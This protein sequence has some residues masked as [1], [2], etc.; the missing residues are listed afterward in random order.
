MDSSIRGLARFHSL[1]QRARSQCYSACDLKKMVDWRVEKL[2]D[3]INIYFR[4]SSYESF[5]VSNLQAG[6]ACDGMKCWVP[7]PNRETLRWDGEYI[8]SLNIRQKQISRNAVVLSS[9][10]GPKFLML[11]SSLNSGTHGGNTLHSPRQVYPIK[12]SYLRRGWDKKKKNWTLR[13]RWVQVG[14]RLL[15]LLSET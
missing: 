3:V 10:Q 11:N 2:T 12:S 13:Y 1:Q 6:S 7:K 9:Q 4:L 15:R 14:H 5:L 8:C